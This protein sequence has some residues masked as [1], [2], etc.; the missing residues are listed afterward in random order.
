MLNAAFEKGCSSLQEGSFPGQVYHS[1]SFSG[2][3]HG[4]HVCHLFL[5]RAPTLKNSSLRHLDE[6]LFFY[7]HGPSTFSEDG[8]PPS[9]NGQL[10]NKKAPNLLLIIVTTQTQ[11]N[12]NKHT[13]LQQFQK[14][15]C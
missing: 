1:S 10:G 15:L 13:F 12:M 3:M 7:I 4:S 14:N 11:A 2:S 9:I 6:I 5:S 8:R